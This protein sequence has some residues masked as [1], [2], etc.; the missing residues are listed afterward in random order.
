MIFLVVHNGLSITEKNQK[1][2]PCRM[3]GK[4]VFGH[5]IFSDLDP[6]EFQERFLTGYRGPR[7]HHIGRATEGK[8]ATHSHVRDAAVF[9][10]GMS[11]GRKSG[12]VEPP[13]VASVK[14]HPRIQRKLDEH[15]QGD[16]SQLHASRYSANFASGCKWWDVSCWLRW[17]FGYQYVGGTREPVYDESSYPS[18]E[19]SPFVEI[20]L[21]Q[22]CGSVVQHTIHNSFENFTVLFF[23]LRLA[24]NGSCHGS[25][26][27]RK[28]W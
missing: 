1:H 24:L 12:E 19:W 13:P 11:K 20:I 9:R 23:S 25:P 21:R 14:R 3:T 22:L 26:F 16:V 4:A 27:T 6:E 17:F 10:I 2:G 8:R 18:G 7:V 15:I 28:L 5:N